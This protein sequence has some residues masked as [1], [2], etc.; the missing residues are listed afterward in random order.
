MESREY[1]KNKERIKKV[2]FFALLLVITSVSIIVATKNKEKRDFVNEQTSLTY[3]FS[4][5]ELAIKY[6]ETGNSE[7]LNEISNL[8]ATIH[9]YNHALHNRMIKPTNSKLEFVT[10]LL[11]PIDKQRELLPIFKE[12]LNFAKE[13]LVKSGIAEKTALQFLPT[14]FIFSGSLFFTF[15]YYH[16]TYGKT[17]NLNLADTNNIKNMNSIIHVAVHELHHVG[18][19][20]LKGGY[21]PSLDITTYKEMLHQIEYVTHLEG[22]GLYAQ[23][24]AFVMLEPENAMSIDI[25]LQELQEFEKEYFDIYYHFKNKPDNL[26]TQEDWNK[27]HILSNGGL[28]YVVGA[29]MVKTIDENLGREKLI[30]LISEPPEN[31]IETYLELNKQ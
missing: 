12:R 23:Q 22:M 3:D 4:F 1:S 14:D 7:C 16:S 10:N 18:F 25:P 13:D 9:L 5:A 30:S 6:L 21:M 2:F 27:F 20:T 26:L 29:H 31:F 28:W 8:D 24:N 11:S 15:G 17:C 19:I